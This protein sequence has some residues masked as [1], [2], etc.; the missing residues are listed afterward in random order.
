MDEFF[1]EKIDFENQ[2]TFLKTTD[3][4]FGNQE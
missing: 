4:Q 2:I 1:I 3:Y